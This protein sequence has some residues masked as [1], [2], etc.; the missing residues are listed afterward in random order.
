[1]AFE[2]DP[3]TSIVREASRAVGDLG[4]LSGFRRQMAGAPQI[5]V[6]VA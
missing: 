2:G 6:E 4:Y 1:M 5:T 3:D